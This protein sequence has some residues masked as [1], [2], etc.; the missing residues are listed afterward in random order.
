MVWTNWIGHGVWMLSFALAVSFAIA[1]KLWSRAQARRSP[2][3]DRKVGHLPGQQLLSRISHHDEEVLTSLNLML[4]A[5]PIMFMAWATTRIDWDQVRWG[6]AEWLFVLGATLMFTWGARGYVRHHRERSQSR[7]GWVAEQVTGIQLNRLVS[8]DCLVLH[9]LPAD[10]FNIDHVVIAPRGVYA[11]ETKS[12]RKPR[13]ATERNDDPSH[14]VT[15]DGSALRF[16][17]FVTKHPIEQA[18]RQAEWLRRLLRSENGLDVPVI[19]AV[20]LPGWFIERT[21]SGKRAEVIV[22][23][24][25]G[26]GAEFMAWQP[27]RIPIDQRRI[28]AQALATRYPA[29]ED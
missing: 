2:L 7:D 25:M 23:T 9:D 19:P 16:P 28:I 5:L 8:T 6:S 1:F 27:E 20:S 26:R 12:F 13:N 15:Y 29:L 3:K 18:S 24:P 17:D 21:D 11:V 14:R 10:G 4:V 22:F